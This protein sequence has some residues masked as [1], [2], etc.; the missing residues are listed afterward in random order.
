MMNSRLLKFAASSSFVMFATEAMLGAKRAISPPAPSLEMVRSADFGTAPTDSQIAS[1]IET[2]NVRTPR[3]ISYLFGVTCDKPRKVRGAAKKW[4]VDIP[5]TQQTTIGC[6][7]L[8]LLA[9]PLLHRWR[10][11]C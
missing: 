4:L 6:G 5:F 11:G 9:P 1:A 7:W 3:V 10:V 2:L 8:V